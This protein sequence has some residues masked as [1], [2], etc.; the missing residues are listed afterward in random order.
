MR[1][2]GRRRFRILRSHTGRPGGPRT[3][4]LAALLS[5]FLIAGLWPP[6]V[7]T[8]LPQANAANDSLIVLDGFGD[9]GKTPETAVLY[10][11]PTITLSG[12]V[13]A[14]I[15]PSGLRL[16]ITNQGQTEDLASVKPIVDGTRFTFRDVPLRPDLN[17]IVFY[18][19]QGVVE[20]TLLT[21][22]V[23]YND[24][25]LITELRVNDQPLS[26][27]EDTPAIVTLPNPDRLTLYVDGR[28]VNLE[29]VWV[30]N[31]RTGD[32]AQADAVGG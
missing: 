32:E 11:S 31:N 4:L 21:F 23:R 15:D 19:R 1:R 18:D 17:T 3:P 14:N 7:L 24:T 12:S 22:Y 25:P 9:R 13:A 16:R 20:R 28:G 2:S 30:K 8:S 27:L 5:L 6:S 26:V 29:Q 10:G